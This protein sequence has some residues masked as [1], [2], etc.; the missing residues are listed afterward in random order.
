MEEKTMNTMQPVVQEAPDGTISFKEGN[1]T[2]IVG[3]HFKKKGKTTLDDKVR[4]LI[5]ADVKAGNF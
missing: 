4:K 1:T 3:I 2:V 5:Q